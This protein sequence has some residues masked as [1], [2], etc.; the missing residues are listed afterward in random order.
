[1]NVTVEDATLCPGFALRL[2]RGVKNG[3]SPEWLVK[4]LEGLGERSI[5]NVADVTNYVMHELGQPM[6]AYDLAKLELSYTNIT[7][8]IDGVIAQRMV[9]QGNLVQLIQ[10]RP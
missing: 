9:K 10:R 1:M 3:P 4:R 2:V 5:N 6:H 7:T 8:P